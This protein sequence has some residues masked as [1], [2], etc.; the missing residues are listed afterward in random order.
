MKY[1]GIETFQ[2]E[3]LST[4]NIDFSNTVSLHFR[5]GD[6]KANP[7]N[8]PILSIDYY[9]KALKN[10]ISKTK[11]DSWIICYCCENND[12]PEVMHK[13]N[14]LQKTFLNLNFI[15]INNILKDWEQMIY[16]SNCKHNIIANSTFS[17]WS[18]YFNKNKEK[19]VY[20]PKIWYS[21]SEVNG[22]HL[23]N[24]IAI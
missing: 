18:A 6:Y 12:Y 24:W 17:W 16:M 15:R 19:I 14:V 21:N 13:I 8:H 9:K 23:K 20:Y 7:K 3:L 22:L 10:L 5:I 1:I 2:N 11:K 4:I